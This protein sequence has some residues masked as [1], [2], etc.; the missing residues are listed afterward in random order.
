MQG[1]IDVKLESWDPAARILSGTSAMVAGDAYEL[2][3]VCPEDLSP[4]NI[5]VNETDRPRRLLRIHSRGKPR[6]RHHHT[7]K[8]PARWIV[9]SPSISSKEPRGKPRGISEFEH[10][11]AFV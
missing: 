4:S 1:L 6:S 10:H 11:L 2:R 8:K 3:L 5:S 7:E 9:L